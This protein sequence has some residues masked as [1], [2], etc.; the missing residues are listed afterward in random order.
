L[1]FFANKQKQARLLLRVMGSNIMLLLTKN[2]HFLQKIAVLLNKIV[3]KNRK[4]LILNDLRASCEN[5]PNWDKCPPFFVPNDKKT[6][7]C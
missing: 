1:T 2:R 3:K 7:K 6:K 5:R 4:S